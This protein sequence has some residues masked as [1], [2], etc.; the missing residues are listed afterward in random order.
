MREV[1]EVLMARA[2]AQAAAKEN[3]GLTM[4][5]K[6]ENRIA[7]FG[8]K[9]DGTFLVEFRAADGQSLA[10]SIPGSEAA[11]LRHFQTRMG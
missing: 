6:A 1:I 4:Q 2:D 7:I 10:I 3:A 5:G 11:V 9:A 8:P